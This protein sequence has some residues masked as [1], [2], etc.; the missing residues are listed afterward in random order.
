MKKYAAVYD[1]EIQEEFDYLDE[2]MDYI[3]QTIHDCYS[4]GDNYT[5][6]KRVCVGSSEVPVSFSE[7]GCQ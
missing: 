2:A 7:E 6:V 5:I 1:G 4:V 3:K